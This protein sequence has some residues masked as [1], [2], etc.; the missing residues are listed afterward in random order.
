M[1]ATTPLPKPDVLICDDEL[2]VRES[3]RLILEGQYALSFAVNGEEAV[4]HVKDHN[5]AVVIMDIKMPVM[6]GLDALAQ[7][8][9]LKPRVP[10]VMITGYESDDVAA[11]AMR[12]GANDYL[13]KPFDRQRI[14]SKIQAIL[15][16]PKD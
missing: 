9:K 12:L 7:I 8:K 5:P 13:T 15:R 14:L 16:P 3:L 11:Q 1:S 4:R 10:V 2:G 6:N